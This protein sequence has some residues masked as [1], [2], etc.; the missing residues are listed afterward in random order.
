M[1][2]PI[3]LLFLFLVANLTL[4]QSYSDIANQKT[5]NYSY[6]AKPIAGLWKV[7]KVFVGEEE[8]TP[9]QDGL[10]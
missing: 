7:D 2:S 4:A 3:I 5:G 8:L 9:L 10:Q 6:V 1:K